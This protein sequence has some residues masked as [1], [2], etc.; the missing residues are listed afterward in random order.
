[1]SAVVYKLELS[2][3]SS[4]RLD[5][6]QIKQSYHILQLADQ[7]SSYRLDLSAKLSN[8]RTPLFYFD[9]QHLDY[10]CPTNVYVKISKFDLHH[11]A[12][13]KALLTRTFCP[14]APY[15]QR[16]HRWQRRNYCVLTL[17]QVSYQ[18]PDHTG[19]HTNK[20]HWRFRR[21]R[22]SQ[23]KKTSKPSKRNKRK[24]SVDWKRPR[25]RKSLWSI[26]WKRR[27]SPSSGIHKWTVVLD[28]PQRRI[29]VDLSASSNKSTTK[30]QP[31]NKELT[32]HQITW[33]KKNWTSWSILRIRIRRK[34]PNTSNRQ[35]L[36]HKRPT[37]RWSV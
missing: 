12:L 5:L 8:F 28:Q 20:F 13:K 35:W 25:K 37:R 22:S 19:T 4:S 33:Y 9:Y 34:V 27:K 36:T 32:I 7:I 18:L 21:R 6:H 15:R 26:C 30:I 24:S 1:M 31:W 10:Y 29:L 11:Q 2:V 16:R 3:M 23:Y 14:L 17:S